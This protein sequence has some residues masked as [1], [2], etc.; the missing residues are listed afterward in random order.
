M[1]LQSLIFCA[2]CPDDT[3]TAVFATG[4]LIHLRMCR[5][6][7]LRSVRQGRGSWRADTVQNLH[8]RR[9]CVL[10]CSSACATIAPRRASGSTLL[11]L[12]RPIMEAELHLHVQTEIRLGWGALAVPIRYAHHIDFHGSIP[13]HLADGAEE[14]VW[15][16]IDCC[17]SRCADIFNPQLSDQ[18]V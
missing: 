1:L 18:T 2:I 5:L 7:M 13:P 8:R 15:A 4:Q 11:P 3:A 17:M 12:L 9:R 10:V 14:C 16:S 6:E